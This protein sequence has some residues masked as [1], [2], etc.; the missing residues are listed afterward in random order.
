MA[1]KWHIGDDESPSS[2]PGGRGFDW[3]FSGT[4]NQSNPNPSPNPNPDRDPDPSP[5]PYPNPSPSPDPN[6]VR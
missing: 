5:S 4:R 6:Q 1:G 3:F 2:N